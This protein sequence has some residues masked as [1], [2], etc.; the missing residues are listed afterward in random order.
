MAIK[1][2]FKQGGVNSCSSNS[3][4]AGYCNIY[5]YL[6]I[7]STICCLEVQTWEVIKQDKLGYLD[8]WLSYELLKEGEYKRRAKSKALFEFSQVVQSVLFL[9]VD[10]LASLA[11]ASSLLLFA[12]LLFAFSTSHCRLI[13]SSVSHCLAV[14]S[15]VLINHSIR[16]RVVY[17]TYLLPIDKRY[18]K[19]WV[20]FISSYSYYRI[21]FGQPT[22][23]VYKLY[24]RILMHYRMMKKNCIQK[25]CHS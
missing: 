11:C 16:E 15:N 3:I 21:I 25:W 4:T 5:G 12:S 2:I 23:P 14:H 22:L 6:L 9:L 8:I 20:G 7:F 18:H 19:E 24:R 17:S 10:F 1:I 13:A